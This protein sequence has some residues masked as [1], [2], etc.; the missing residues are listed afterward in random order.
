MKFEKEANVKIIFEGEKGSGKSYLM[1]KIIKKLKEEKIT[2]D[3]DK[4]G[5]EHIIY[6]NNNH[7]YK[8]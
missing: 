8:T 3:Y 5:N 4:F 1:N 2:H 6:V 7:D